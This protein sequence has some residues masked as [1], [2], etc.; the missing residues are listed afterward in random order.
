MWCTSISI[1]DAIKI[2]PKRIFRNIAH[3]KFDAQHPRAEHVSKWFI[4]YIL[5]IDVD[6]KDTFNW[7]VISINQF[8]KNETITNGQI[9]IGIGFTW[10]VQLPVQYKLQHSYTMPFNLISSFSAF[11]SPRSLSLS[12]PLFKGEGWK[13]IF[14]TFLSLDRD[15]NNETNS[16]VNGSI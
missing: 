10:C 12:F 14:H 16:R 5:S 1:E 6:F 13:S 3:Q 7:T 2:I 11:C 4:L 15:E 8:A 9:W